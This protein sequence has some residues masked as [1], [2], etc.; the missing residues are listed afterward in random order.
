MAR[1]L[2]DLIANVVCLVVLADA[3]IVK[4]QVGKGFDGFGAGSSQ[5]LL[6]V[7]AGSSGSKVFAFTPQKSTGKLLTA[8]SDKYRQLGQLNQ[9]IAALAYDKSE[10][11]WLVGPSGDAGGMHPLATP[12]PDY[13][14][15]LLE[16]LAS[17]Y[18]TASKQPDVSAVKNKDSIPML[19]TAG[20]RLVS[21]AKNAQ[22]WSYLCGK[23]HGGLTLAPAGPK[24]GTIPGTKEA[25]YEY[26][27]NAADG[28]KS[29][30]LTGTFTVGG[31]SAQVAIPLK[32]A[33]DVSAFQALRKR[34]GNDLDC[35][36]LRIP[37]GSQAPIFNTKREGGPAKECL[38]DYI[39]FME[40]VDIHATDKVEGDNVKTQEIEGLGLISF[41]G[42]RGKGSFV[43]GGVNEIG[44][45]AKEVG[46]DSNRTTFS[47][48]SQRMRSAL[49]KDI[50][51]KHVTDYFKDSALNINSFSYNTHAA[52][53]KSAGL[54]NVD[55]TDQGWELEEELKHKC[56][57]DNSVRFGYKNS[58]S[59]MSALYTSLF[60]TSF[61]VEKGTEDAHVQTELNWDPIRDWAEGKVEEARA[62]S[63]LQRRHLRSSRSPTMLH[64]LMRVPL[65]RHEATYMDGAAL[66]FDSDRRR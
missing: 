44:H 52:R 56:Q 7:D 11:D 25:Y 22:V 66:F 64:S 46:C 62:L 49:S 10:C 16:L 33:A 8:C 63:L 58:S 38:D 4:K 30:T 32:T 3:Q 27:A 54:P 34:V 36:K 23:S 20:M 43:A 40:K 65:R 17:T 1:R 6:L 47:E 60:V 19:A 45:W 48:C 18:S 29:R 53:P 59:C 5:S 61:F 2:V 12:D 26:L 39:T 15:A 57:S 9:G 41:L 42:L 21:Q 35:T 55:G 14:N 28:R 51:W 37:D 13:A 31:A 50:M 24:C